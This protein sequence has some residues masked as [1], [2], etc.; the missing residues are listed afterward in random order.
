M[1]R[2]RQFN[3]DMAVVG[4]YY[5]SVHVAVALVGSLMLL[6][7]ASFWRGS[8]AVASDSAA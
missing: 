7:A 5:R 1:S 2:P 3:L 6:C 4:S 8:L